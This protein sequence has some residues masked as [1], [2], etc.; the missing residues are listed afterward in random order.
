MNL[1]VTNYHIEQPNRRYTPAFKGPLDG[2]LTGTLRLLD[3]NEMANAVLIDLGA[4]VAPRTYID[5]KKRNKD[6]GFE[7][8]FREASGTFINCLSAGLIASGISAL[9]AK[10]LQPEVAINPKSWFSDD[11]IV[12]LKKA[13]DSSSGN[14]ETYVA[15]ILDNMSAK[16]GKRAA[17]FKDINWK[18]VEWIDEKSWKN[19]WWNNTDYVKTA[20]T[21]KSREGIINTFAAVIKDKNLD[22]GDKKYI[23]KIMEARITNALGANRSVDVNIGGSKW[24]SA[25]SH[26]LRDTYDMGKDVFTN[27]NINIDAAIAK[28][29]R[30]NKI[31]I[32]GALSLAS[33][34]GL[35]N[36][37]LNRKLTEKRTGKKGFVGDVDYKNRKKS[38]QSPNDK[39]GLLFKKLIASVGM[40]AMT[41]GVMRV[42]SPKDFIRKLQFTG[43]VSSGNAIKTVYASTIIGRFL[44][45]DST[46]E[47]RESITRDYFGFLNWLVLGGFAA[48][49]TA[50]L[51][52]K[53][54]E[55][56]FN[57][58]KEGKG[59]KHWLNDITLKTHAEIAAKGK[60]FAKKNIWKLNT[61]HI[62]G[63]AY[64]ALALGVLLPV[65]NIY[66]TNKKAKN[67]PHLTA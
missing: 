64:S 57:I 3:T 19:F 48:K 54:Q 44:A 35:T 65:I 24:N 25:L 47:L 5:T 39:K 16:D 32:F 13:W 31:K 15:N 22:A 46:T 8:F 58:N 6:A 21:L 29:K 37:Y 10:R 11:S 34:L 27:K 66:M 61:A 62:A 51:L 40:A 52:D 33:I 1:A 53:K 59:I 50:N 36:Q 4:M 63:L 26:I 60:E 17:A 14:V 18:N 20:E 43:P 49:G 2:A 23:F 56:L 28:I 12:V 45:A 55:N 30:V 42:K 67:K 7:T 9:T 38:V 41:I